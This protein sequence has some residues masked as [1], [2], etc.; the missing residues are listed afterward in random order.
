MTQEE[1]I[2][3]VLG[4]QLP[5][6]DIADADVDELAHEVTFNL[7]RR[8]GVP[9]TC[10]YCGQQC[11]FAYDRLSPRCVE[12][13]PLGPFRLFWRF[14]P[15][16]IECPHC[17]RVHVE[18]IAGLTLRSR[19]TDRFR[20]YLARKCENASVSSVARDYGLNDETVRRI[21]REFLGKRELITP[22]A[23]CEKL[24]ID[25]IALCKGHVYATVFYDHVR[26]NVLH[27]VQGRDRAAVF[28]FFESMGEKW[29]SQV[30]V[31]TADLWQP[32]KSAVKKYL[33]NAKMTT[34]KFHVHK[35]AGDA[36][37][38]VRRS[39]YARQCDRT[40]FDLKRARFLIQKPNA[41]LDANGLERIRQ[42]KETNE[43][44]YT[45]YLLKEQVFA[46][47][48]IER[49]EVAE[50]FLR[51]WASACIASKLDP[52][53]K[54]GRRLLRHAESILQYF[55]HRVSNSFAE[56]INNKIKVIKRMAFGFHDFEYFRL[57]IL[58]ATGYLR[59]F[60]S[61]TCYAANTLPTL[62]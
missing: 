4:N 17:R 44:V 43:N 30:K 33:H 62:L 51:K 3:L 16:R 31:V 50:D 29:C 52:F 48:S 46:F 39:E 11:F 61:L 5:Q 55:T 8:E 10:L 15:R 20:L 18:K 2:K 25:E 54:L 1:V 12:D 24:G 23:P 60:P 57:K 38:E 47:Y 49:R 59:P 53:V 36:L 45:G 34:D 21:D 7:S 41:K 27:M 56:G 32:Y 42:L 37:D 19:Q 22:S 40:D 35:Y 14:A 58:A 9:Y 26:K 13:I 28:A 6:F